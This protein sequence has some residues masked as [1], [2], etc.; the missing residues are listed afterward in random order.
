MSPCGCRRASGGTKRFLR[1]ATASGGTGGS[2]THTHSGQ[3]QA[4]QLDDQEDVSTSTADLSV[5]VGGHVHNFTTSAASSLPSYYET[6]W[7]MRV[8]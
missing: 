3:T 6:V 4:T 5:T 7:V 2:E 1:G 8:K